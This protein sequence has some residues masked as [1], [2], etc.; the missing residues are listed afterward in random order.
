VVLEIDKMYYDLAVAGVPLLAT[1]YT[2]QKTV[3]QEQAS[4]FPELTGQVNQS[5]LF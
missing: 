1:L 3:T 5:A 2:S 4:L